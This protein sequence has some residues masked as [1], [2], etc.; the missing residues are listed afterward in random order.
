METGISP[1]PREL[2]SRRWSQQEPEKSMIMMGCGDSLCALACFTCLLFPAVLKLFYIACYFWGGRVQIG[3]YQ[4]AKSILSL[5]GLYLL[6]AL[7]VLLL[8]A[9]SNTPKGL[10]ALLQPHRDIQKREMEE[11]N[12]VLNANISSRAE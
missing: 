1:M 3:N 11:I 6:T 12:F 5:T 7:P 4:S 10:L 8:L 9:W 2:T